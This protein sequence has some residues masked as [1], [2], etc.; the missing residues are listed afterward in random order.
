MTQNTTTDDATDEPAVNSFAAA[1]HAAGIHDGGTFWAAP[2]GSEIHVGV[3]PG[4][5]DTADE[6]AQNHGLELDR[7]E[8]TRRVYVPVE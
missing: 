4:N 8:L 5:E 6:L 3:V 7:A 1:I 2:N